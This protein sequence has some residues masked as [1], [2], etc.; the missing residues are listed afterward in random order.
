MFQPTYVN[1][2]RRDLIKKLAAS[3]VLITT[4]SLPLSL[5]NACG[6]PNG[7]ASL[8]QDITY[9]TD[10][11]YE[12]LRKNMLYKGNKPERYP[13]IIVKPNTEQEIT[14]A[15]EFAS[16]KDLQVVCRTSG[17]NTAGAVLRNGGM[18]IDLSG[19]NQIE[20]DQKAMSAT[21]GPGVTM[22]AFYGAISKYNLGFP[23]ADCL[24]VTFGG[25][26]LGGG[27]GKNGNHWTKG[28][29]CNALISADILLASGER[30]TVD[31]DHYPDIFWSI[32][33]CGPAFYGII[34]NYKLRLFENVGAI[35]RSSYRYKLEAL[36]EL[37]AFFDQYQDVKDDRV[38]TGIALFESQES[39]GEFGVRVSLQAFVQNGSEDP[40][41]EANSLLAFYEEKGVAEGAYEVN[42][43]EEYQMPQLLMSTDRKMYTNTD[44]V[45]TDDANSLLALVDLFKAK[46]VGCF[47][48]LTLTHGFQM[49]P[50][51]EDA[52]Y[53]AAGSHFLSYHFNWYD[54]KDTEAAYSWMKEFSDLAKPYG[55]NHYINQA[56]NERFPERIRS[57][58]TA[59]NWSKLA[60]IRKKYDPENRFFTYLGYS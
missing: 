23:I 16:E 9:K 39:P 11:G 48:L 43:P 46:P 33:G 3:G 12:S 25:Y 45:F 31:R 49:Y 5:L 34:L 41:A 17:H 35:A 54:D 10:D 42:K 22:G 1:P 29:A 18:L 13:D 7:K 47:V 60:Q 40:L 19:F 50:S 26:I 55:I 58:F 20:I 36:P 53:S 21:V 15:L 52:C 28:P 37:L 6:T 38:G 32:K 59:E 51:R 27:H 2:E 44:N 57:C 56:D 24:T 14:G 30:I 8:P 4:G